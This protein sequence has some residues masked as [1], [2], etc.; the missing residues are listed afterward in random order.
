MALA[1]TLPDLIATPAGL[2]YRAAD[3][4][5]ARISLRSSSPD[6]FAVV[7]RETGTLLGTVDGA[8]ADSTV[9]EGAVYLHM[10]EQYL[11]ESADSATRVAL[12]TPFRGD[13]Y[14]QVKRHSATVV[15]AE[16][17]ARRL[18][19]ADLWFGEIEVTEQVVGYQRRRLSDHRPID[20]VALEMPEHRFATEA[21]W[22]APTVPPPRE[23]LL[24]ALHAAEHAV[25]GLL[26]LLAICDRGD[27][28]G[29][30]TDMHPQTG[31]PTVF[32]YDG[33][34]GGAGIALRGFELFESWVQRTA[35]LLRDCPCEA[36]CPSCVQSP[37]CGNLN[38]PLHKGAAA[39]LLHAIDQAGRAA[40][41]A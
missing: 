32:V 37:K 36:G 20:L 26:P 31:R 3:H 4:P 22:F 41:H 27:I 17:Q 38:E 9:H 34:P 18:P 24:G 16:R 12:V 14:T 11:V 8:R 35:D 15:V 19:G 6:A 28:G 30:S 25:I 10:G 13:W 40:G 2:A 21:V 5:A 23:V 1:A 33:H 39:A 7:E 29:L